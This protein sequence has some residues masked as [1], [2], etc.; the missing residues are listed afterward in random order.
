MTV[1]RRMA[2]PKGWI[3]GTLLFWNAMI[4]IPVFSI[5]YYKI[6]YWSSIY[7]AIH[8]QNTHLLAAIVAY[9]FYILLDP[10]PTRGGWAS[11]IMFP[12]SWWQG[13]CNRCSCFRLL[14]EYFDMELIHE[15][16]LDPNQPYV[17]VYHPH[18]IIGVGICGALST[19]GA[20]FEKHFP[21]VRYRHFNRRDYR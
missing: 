5:L 11:T 12:S 17:F 2:T 7:Y 8:N 4:T 20:D 3:R 19:N 18:G 13:W 6:L 9:S 1:V 10:S 14:A 15:K 21:G 16:E